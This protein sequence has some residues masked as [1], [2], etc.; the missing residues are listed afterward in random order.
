MAGLSDFCGTI[1]AGFTKCGKSPSV[2]GIEPG[3]YVFNLDEFTITYDATNPL[4]VTGF[5][6]ADNTKLFYK[7]EGY[8]DNFNA[9]SKAT[10]KMVGPR[11]TETITAYVSDNST[12]T[13]KLIHNG[14][15][16]RL[17]FVVINNDKATDGAVEL[18]GAVNGLQ[19]SDNTERDAANED[20]QGAWKIEATNPPKLLEPFP[21]R[22]VLIP[23]GTGEATYASTLAALELLLAAG[24]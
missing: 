12:D 23:P 6:R 3:I 10:K 20:M 22:A 21:P 2:A 8:G 7:L 16:G 18:Y 4:I 14:L 24:V 15:T 9:V 11:Y 5:T 19:F 1:A 13:K 17:G